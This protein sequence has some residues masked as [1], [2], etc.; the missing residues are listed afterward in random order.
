MSA[1]PPCGDAHQLALARAAL[2]RGLHPGN[3]PFVEVVLAQFPA[4]AGAADAVADLLHTEAVL[5]RLGGQPV[6]LADLLGRFPQHGPAIEARWRLDAEL[7][8][9][10]AAPPRQ[11]ATVAPADPNATVGGEAAGPP[12]GDWPSVPGH[13][14]LGELGRG[15]MG[16]VYLARQV[17]LRRLVALKMILAGSAAGPAE[18]QRFRLEA[19]A[20]ASLQH[21]HIVQI[22]EVGEVQLG[23]GTPCP[24]LALEYCG[25]GTLA[26]RLGRPLGDRDAAA[27]V[28]VLAGAVSAAHEKAIVHRDLKPGN[29]LLTEDGQLKITDFGLAKVCDL[30][31]PA[32]ENLTAT[33][34]VLGTPGYLAPEQAG[35]KTRQVGPAADVYA[36]GAILYECLTG[37]PP[38]QAGTVLDT[39]V[40][41]VGQEPVP[42]RQVNP[43][44]TR[45]LETI[46]L[47]C[48]NKDPA[49]R[50][51]TAKEMAEDLRR[52]LAGEPIKARPQ[53]VL[54]RADR[55]VR[56][57]PQA[58]LSWAVVLGL[59]G[60]LVWLFSF[61]PVQVLGLKGQSAAV[62]LGVSLPLA[63]AVLGAMTRAD[64]RVS[65][66][67]LALAA[68]GC[69]FWRYRR[70][71]LPKGVPSLLASFS[72]PEAVGSLAASL[73]LPVLPAVLLG[74]VWRRGWREGLFWLAALAWPLLALGRTEYALVAVHGLLAGGFVWLVRGA[75]RREAGPIALGAFVG[76]A[77]G[78]GVGEAYATSLSNALRTSVLPTW[79]RPITT[80]YLEACCAFVGAVAGG[81]VARRASQRAAGD[82]A[83]PSVNA[84]R[85][86]SASV[87]SA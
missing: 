42:P 40:L 68:G 58:V 41:V 32:G 20:L 2:M 5:R 56:R 24:F 78:V 81:L 66:L 55:W 71:G 62:L 53:G 13:E 65:P 12:T 25:G 15:G 80:L 30:S 11:A 26:A 16:V 29:V 3:R 36:L 74:V 39:L 63:L 6:T 57:N 45:D 22:Y 46:C 49:H 79:P 23:S 60:A 7:P 27:A 87:R 75:L 86:T 38:F 9:G 85:S 44:V 19:Q 82:Q 4:L 18:M 8:P 10:G 72:L 33:G 54:R 52:F 35:G 17:R 69:A 84:T 1:P 59:A 48:L 47:K 76:V 34:S 37:R 51:P 73:V 14:I 50:Y 43:R 61:D 77:A 21:P 28:A 31:A 70:P 64:G 67:A 83:V